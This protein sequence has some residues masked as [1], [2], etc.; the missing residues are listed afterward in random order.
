MSLSD[1]H[2][3]SDLYSNDYFTMTTYQPWALFAKGW[4]IVEI[5]Q[6][7]ETHCAYSLETIPVQNRGASESE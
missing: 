4:T 1:I 3:I 5:A 2:D 7:K 6:A